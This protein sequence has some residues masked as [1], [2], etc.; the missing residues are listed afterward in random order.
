MPTTPEGLGLPPRV[1]FYTVD[2]IC[3]ILELDEN[4]V[5]KNM[6]HYEGRSAGIAPRGKLRAINVAPPGEKPEWRISERSLMRYLK[7]AGM[8]FYERGYAD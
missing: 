2:Q 4:Y 7:A 1:F 8:K 3:G 6:L 5:K